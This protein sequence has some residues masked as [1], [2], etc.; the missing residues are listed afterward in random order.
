MNKNTW[1]EIRTLC[2]CSTMLTTGMT[3][4]RAA[5]DSIRGLRSGRA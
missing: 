5:T 4:N 3:K 1:N 2:M